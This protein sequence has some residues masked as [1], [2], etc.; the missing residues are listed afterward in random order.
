M[1]LPKTL[2]VVVL[3][4]AVLGCGDDPA[5]SDASVALA[6][7]SRD[8]AVVLADAATAADAGS[9]DAATPVDGAASDAAGPIDAGCRAFEVYD[10]VTGRCESGP[11]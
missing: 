9:T 7:G 11:G 10:P 6:D 4:S 8:A 3:A 1:R 5:S 2:S